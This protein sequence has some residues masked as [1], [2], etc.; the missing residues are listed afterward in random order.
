MVLFAAPLNGRMSLTNVA[1]ALDE[2]TSYIFDTISP[3]LPSKV[4]TVSLNAAT[5]YA[6]ANRLFNN[7]ISPGCIFSTGNLEMKPIQKS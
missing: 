5:K 2:G 1:K 7:E 3:F 6:V 4:S